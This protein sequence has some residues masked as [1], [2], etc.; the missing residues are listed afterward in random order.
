[1]NIYIRAIDQA[2]VAIPEAQLES[3]RKALVDGATSLLGTSALG[4]VEQGSETRE[5]V[6]GWITVLWPGINEGNL[7][8]H[9]EV[10][11]QRMWLNY[12]QTACGVCADP[13]VTMRP[14]SVKHEPAAM[15]TGH[16]ARNTNAA[17]VYKRPNGNTD[18]DVDPVSQPVPLSISSG[19][20]VV[21]VD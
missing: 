14:R 8:G 7:C 19:R 16:R 15:P 20:P 5:N 13:A 12:K 10:G 18:I 9:A 4:A 1:M 6:P 11:G 21:V 3:T 17:I 2:G